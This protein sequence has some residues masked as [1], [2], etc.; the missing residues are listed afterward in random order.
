M[1][2][3]TVLSVLILVGVCAGAA[4]ADKYEPNEKP[5]TYD[6]GAPRAIYPED[7]G[8]NNA[9]PGQP[10]ACGDQ[11]D[12]AALTQGDLDWTYLDLQAGTL[13]TISTAP[14]SDLGTD[15]YLEVY[16]SCTGSILISDDD[17]GP[18]FYSLISN[19]PV[20]HAG[21]YYIKVRGYSTSS[22]GPY[23]LSVTCGVPN[24]PDPNDT[25]NP[26]IAIQCGT[27]VLNGD[28][29]WDNN[30]YDPLSGGCATQYPEAGKDVAYRM[31]L[32]VGAVIDMTYYTP[33][34]DAAFYIVTDCANVP[35][36]CVVG[37]DAGYDTET[38]HYV[39]PNAGTYWLI[40][41][42]YGTNTGGGPWT[43]NYTINCQAEPT[44]ACCID[45]RC[46]ITTEADCGG[47]WLGPNY[48]TCDPN[49]CP[50]PTK[51][52]SWGQIK[53]TYR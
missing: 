52:S 5:W 40:L 41:D 26:D 37:A 47:Q 33:N 12:P 29:T 9:C 34:W 50:T 27:G 42:H 23:V 16:D 30:N 2:F 15:T 44:G 1:R 32:P 39:V 3:V 4:L 6:P 14:P 36:T 21:T 46:S 19:W 10:M 20:P 48:P 43:L 18:G 51:E 13:L 38:I 8:V 28:M 53:V 24:P 17:S 25:C 11:I 31:D 35:G 7:E 49:P 45:G 22:T